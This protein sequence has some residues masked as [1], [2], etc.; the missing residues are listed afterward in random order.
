M[1]AALDT[2]LLIYAEGCGDDPRVSATRQLLD[3][4]GEMFRLL[5]EDLNPGC[6]WRG[7]RVVNPLLEP[8]DPLFLQL[9]G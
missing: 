7:V 3:Q 2:N 4:L 5:T 8:I 9:L 1:R 6:S